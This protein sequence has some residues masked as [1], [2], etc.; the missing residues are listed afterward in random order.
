MPRIAVTCC[1]QPHYLYITRYRC[2]LLR[3]R[4][5]CRCYSTPLASKLLAYRSRLALPHPHYIFPCVSH[6]RF[7]MFDASLI[8]LWWRRLE[9]RPHRAFTGIMPCA[10]ITFVQPRVPPPDNNENVEQTSRVST[11]YYDAAP[12]SSFSLAAA[13][14]AP[15]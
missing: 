12:F 7:T 8:T 3:Q 11:S 6:D 5:H 2:T 13:C 1:Y 4:R 10:A 15:W 14:L 9:G